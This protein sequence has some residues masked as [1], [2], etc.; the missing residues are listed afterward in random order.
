MLHRFAN[1]ARFARLA[2]TILPWSAAATVVLM[3]A[4][5]WLALFASPAAYQQGETVR[6]LYVHVPAPWVPI[7]CYTFMAA[8]GPVEIGQT[9]VGGRVLQD[10]VILGVRGH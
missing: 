1:P 9:S 6:M 5:I 3:A 7:A 10:C 2:A 8:M 4:G